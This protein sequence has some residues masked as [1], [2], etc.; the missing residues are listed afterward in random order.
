MVSPYDPV[1]SADCQVCK[2]EDIDLI[3]CP[4]CEYDC[5]C[6]RCGVCSHCKTDTIAGTDQA[7]ID[8]IV[9]FFKH[10]LFEEYDGM[11]FEKAQERASKSLKKNTTCG[12]WINIDFE[13]IVLGSIVEGSDAEC[14]P[15]RLDYPFTRTQY[16]NAIDEIEDQADILWKEAN[17]DE[18]DDAGQAG[19][20]PSDL[21]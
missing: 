4:K 19:G 6:P 20:L 13:G 9:D 16:E 11:G 10:C 8:S 17:T 14:T 1:P 7:Y 3:N 18:Q 5:Y 12:A 21:G 15:H 2:L